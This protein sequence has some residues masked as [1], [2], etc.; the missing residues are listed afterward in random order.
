MASSSSSPP[1]KIGQEYG[2]VR[3]S[4]PLERLVPYLEREI[5]GFQG[6]VEVKQFKVCGFG[7]MVSLADC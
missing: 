2:D 1:K 6:P 5:E 3:S 4:L 7:Y